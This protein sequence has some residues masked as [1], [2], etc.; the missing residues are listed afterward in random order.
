[1]Y[2]ETMLLD[3]APP[4]TAADAAARQYVERVRCFIDGDRIGVEL[5]PQESDALDA[6]IA[7][8]R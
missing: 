3:V 2:Q 1:M 4:S 8:R 5:E 6:I 7:G